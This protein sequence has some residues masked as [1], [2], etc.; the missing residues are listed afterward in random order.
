MS[1]RDVLAYYESCGGEPLSEPLLDHLRGVGEA[2][3]GSWE[4]PLGRLLRARFGLSN[5]FADVLSMAAALHDIGKAVVR[6]VRRRRG[7]VH[8]SFIGHEAVSAHVVARVMDS[9]GLL[10]EG[11]VARAPV[12]AVLYHHHAMGTERR[13]R[14]RGYGVPEP[15]VS[16]PEELADLMAEAVSW[17][18]SRVRQ[19]VEAVAPEVAE[20]ILRNPSEVMARVRESVEKDLWVHAVSRRGGL[21]L[22]AASL[23]AVVAAD[24]L[25][26]GR[27][28]RAPVSGFARAALGF[29]TYYLGVAP[30]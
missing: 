19:A 7:C 25:T 24:Y 1:Y 5:D 3:R 29:A 14:A 17:L 27:A 16:G 30:G 20:E 10:G 12:F 23:A 8:Y 26:A 9:G 21:S 22:Y 6:Y 28:R 11:W 18:P 4:A 2:V 15:Q 13:I